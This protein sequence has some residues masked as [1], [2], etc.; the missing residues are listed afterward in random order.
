MILAKSQD[1][2]IFNTSGDYSRRKSAGKEDYARQL[3]AQMAEKVIFQNYDVIITKFDF[4]NRQKEAERRKQEAY[5][6]KLEREMMTYDPFGKGGGGAPGKFWNFS[7]SKIQFIF[8]VRDIN[9]RLMTDLRQMKT[10]ND[11]V[12]NNL[13]KVFFKFYFRSSKARF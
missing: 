2:D 6:K 9:G 8:L 5:D 12:M 7:S 10:V 3:A 11:T 1:N 4:Q 13:D